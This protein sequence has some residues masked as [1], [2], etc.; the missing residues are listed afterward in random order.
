MYLSCTSP[1]LLSDDYIQ[2]VSSQLAVVE[3]EWGYLTTERRHGQA[4]GIDK[5]LPHRPP[6]LLLVTCLSCPEV[7]LNMEDGWEDCPSDLRSDFFAV[8]RLLSHSLYFGSATCMRGCG[9]VT[10]TISLATM[11]RIAT[12]RTRPYS[13]ARL[14]SRMT[15]LIDVI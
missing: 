4:H 11:P 2:N 12:L 14:S 1:G 6:N 7:G 8:L 15:K 5:Y 9:L 10:A 13:K 3:R